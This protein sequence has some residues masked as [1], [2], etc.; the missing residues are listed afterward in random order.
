MIKLDDDDNFCIDDFES[1]EEVNKYLLKLL[2][3]KNDKIKNDLMLYCKYIVQFYDLE[4]YKRNY[5]DI[6]YDCFNDIGIEPSDIDYTKKYLT[7]MLISKNYMSREDYYK[8]IRIIYFIDESKDIDFVEYYS[9]DFINDHLCETSY[10][11]SISYRMNK[12]YYIIN[13]I[14]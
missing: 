11:S 2:G 10:W 13:E 5:L 8:L 4:N 7:M 12:F 1:F 6:H 3:D 9:S 14:T